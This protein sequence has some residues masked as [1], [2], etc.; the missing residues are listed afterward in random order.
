MDLHNLPNVMD[1]DIDKL[2]DALSN[3]YQAQL[4]SSLGEGS[5]A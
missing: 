1:G 4:L 2:I 3:T 5:Q